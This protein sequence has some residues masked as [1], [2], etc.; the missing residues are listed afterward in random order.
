MSATFDQLQADL[1]SRGPDAMLDRLT[2]TLRERKDYHGLF[3]TML[4]RKR[5][6]LGLPPVHV[7]ASE[8]L[9][10]AVQEQY[11]TAIREAARTVGQTYL[12]AGDIP[13]AWPFFRMINEPA[14]VAEALDKIEPPEEG[15]LSQQLIDIA[16]REGAH[17]RRGFDLVLKRFGICS[18][19]TMFS[20]DFPFGPEVRE[21]CIKRLVRNLYDD[22]RDRLAHEV[23]RREGSTPN[24]TTIHDLLTGRDSLFEDEA[25]Y[26]DTSH[27]GAVVQFSSQLQ[28]C[29]ELDLAIELCE[30]GMKLSPKFSYPGEPPFED[31]Y[32]DY[33]V[34]LR[35]LAGRDV[36]EG[37]SHFRSKAERAN[38]EE[39]GTLPAEVLVNLLV[40]LGRHEAAVEAFGRFLAEANGR[41]TCPTL[42]E[43]CQKAS[44]Y[45]PLIEVSRKR[46]DLVNFAAGLLQVSDASA[47]RR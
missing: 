43:L 22:L 7:G 2:E 35:T 16:L 42:Q 1:K 23:A 41:L 47:K 10:P 37:I 19:I 40:R 38:P 21:H 31:M 30:Y 28:P 24:E 26:I 29:E 44:D 15:D 17:P 20:Q 4:L 33:H 32:R 39:D 3:Y 18:A 6:E 45:R 13:G 5:L 9:P 8:E 11:E 27:L 36:E 12:D 25:Y 46:D 34:Y 14:K